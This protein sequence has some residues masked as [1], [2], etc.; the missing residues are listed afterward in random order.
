MNLKKVDINCDVGEGIDNE[1]LLFPYIHTCNI[2]CGGHAGDEGTI[3]K[4]A[5][6]AK[7]Y[8]LNIGAHP[9]YPDKEYF[10]RKVLLISNDE[11]TATISSQLELFGR[12]TEEEKASFY[13]VKPHGALYNQ[14]AID[15]KVAKCIVAA[16]KALKKQVKLIAPFNSV[17]ANLAIKNSIEVIYEAFADRNY[18]NDLSLVSRTQ[19]NA[20]I[21]NPK[22][23]LEQILIML[24][25]AK[26]KTVSGEK[27]SIKA[28]TYCIHGDNPKVVEILKTLSKELPKHG[29]TI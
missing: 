19:Q 15:E 4:I 1:A 26:V 22:E 2:A 18:N 8:H 10:G 25:E 5:R 20:I 23:I 12:V 21:Y 6:L 24:N 7:Q 3:R 28:T 16:V 29:Y 17:I 27:V 9:S 13:H 14:A 11:L